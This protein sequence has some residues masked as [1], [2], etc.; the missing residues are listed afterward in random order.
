MMILLCDC[1]G[2]SSIIHYSSWKCKRV[3]RSILAAEVH[4]LT[5]CFDYC[6]TV[7]HDLTTILSHP[8]PIEIFTDSKSIFDTGTKLTSVTEKHLLI[9]LSPLREAYI[10]GQIRNL[11]NVLSQYSF[12]DPL[13]KKRS[14]SY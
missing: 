2:S 4:A 8:I 14:L 9:D 13:T 11:A 1:N 12:A 5:A 10:S 3:T 6:F 7:A